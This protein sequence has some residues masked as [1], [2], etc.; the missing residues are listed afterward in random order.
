MNMK[1]R[2][3]NVLK[4]FIAA[5]TVAS[6]S[7]TFTFTNVSIVNAAKTVSTTATTTA[8]KTSEKTTKTTSVKKAAVKKS[9]KVTE[10]KTSVVK[11]ADERTGEVNDKLLSEI[12]SLR[13]SKGLGELK[14]DSTLVSIAGTR[15]EEASEKWSHER[16]NG[17]QG[18]DMI[19]S[20]RW[21]GENLSYVVYPGYEGSEKE[22]DKVVEKMF[23]SL[24]ASPTH[25]DNM[26]F[27][28]FTKIGIA[29]DISETSEGTK[30]TTAYMFSN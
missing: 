4:A 2:T 25:Y 21:R 27:G 16:P 29:T 5:V 23:D 15:S 18:I 13:A 1:K 12:N 8:K 19:D 22:Q 30:L 7:Y 6:L 3:K 14:M 9:S 17:E 20:T 11:K 10:V 28:N 24:V 26:V